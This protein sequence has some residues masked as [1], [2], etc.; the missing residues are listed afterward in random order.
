LQ[1]WRWTDLV[2][3]IRHGTL[4]TAQEPHSA[5]TAGKMTFA[6]RADPGEP[7]PGRRHDRATLLTYSRAI[8]LLGE[9]SGGGLLCLAGPIVLWGGDI[10]GFHPHPERVDGTIGGPPCTCGARLATFPRLGGKMWARTDSRIRAVCP[11][12]AAAVVPDG[13]RQRA[14]IPVV[15]G[16][17]VWAKMMTDLSFGG[18]QG[19]KRRISFGV[20]GNRVVPLLPEHVTFVCQN[21]VGVVTT[22]ALEVGQKVSTPPIDGQDFSYADALKA[23]GLPSDFLLAATYPGRARVASPRLLTACRWP[24]PGAGQGGLGSG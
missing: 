4:G 14:P 15:S 6:R 2:D 19:R 1:P 10:R 7:P 12:G 18:T 17:A 11:R 21:P 23:Q 22:R 24:G 5:A 8:D 20:R 16:Y 3:G 13:E 9:P